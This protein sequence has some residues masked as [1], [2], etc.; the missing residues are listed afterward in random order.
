[1][2]PN[3]SGTP[4][5]GKLFVKICVRTEASPLSRPSR[6]G[7]LAERAS[8]W[9]QHRPEAIAD[10][11]RAVESPHPDMDMQAESVVAPCDPAEIVLDPAVVLGVDDLLIAVIGPWMGAGGGQCRPVGDGE[12]EQAAAMVSLKG[13]GLGEVRPGTRTD[14]DLGSDQLAGHRS[15]RAGSSAAAS[16]G[17]RSAGPVQA[18]RGRRGA[19]SSSSPTVPSVEPAKTSSARSKS[20]PSAIQPQPSGR[21]GQVR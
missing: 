14:L 20:I 21:A 19:N 6:N 8:N 7:E 16:R 3:A 4:Q 13:L 11:D 5:R 17:A 10:P 12:A 1:M 18:S 9:R 2:P 15:S